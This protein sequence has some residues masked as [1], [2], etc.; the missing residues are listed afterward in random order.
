MEAVIKVENVF[1]S[2]PLSKEPVL[3]NISFEI[4]RGEVFAIIGNNGQGKTTLCNLIRGFIPRIYNGELSGRICLNG[5][6]LE[7]ISD[8]QLVQTVGYLFQ[9]PYTQLSHTKKTVFEEIAFGLENLGVPK[10]DIL[11]RVQETIDR[12]GIAQLEGKNPQKLS[13]GQMQK[14]A[15]ASVLVMEPDI[16]IVDE[17]TSQLDPKSTDEIF[18]IICSLREK[19]ITTII[20]EHKMDL[21]C[22]YADH[23][24]CIDDGQIVANGTPT[25]VFENPVLRE[26]QVDIP[27]FV[28]AA[29][30]M[31]ESGFQIE[32]FPDSEER[33][34]RM[35][36]MG[37]E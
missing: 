3:K 15:F 20:V 6:K 19:R 29:Q 16:L 25:E 8:E 5:E 35:I 27:A 36:E 11:R 34:L 37:A 32:T 13:G 7:Q 24:I 4:Q 9:N 14:V 21:I 23:V 17:P 22:K 1:Y 33:F 18:E 10:P 30:L 31:R 28:T 2:Y 12:L 26:K